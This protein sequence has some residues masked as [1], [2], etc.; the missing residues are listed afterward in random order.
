MEQTV[1]PSREE[2]ISER[3]VE[4]SIDFSVSG[5]DIPTR[6]GLKVF[7]QDRVRQRHLLLF[8]QLVQMMTRM[9]LMKGFFA[10]FPKIKV[11]SWLRT[12][13]E[14]ARQCQPI[15]AGCSAGG[16]AIAGLHRVSAAQGKL[17]WQDPLLEQTHKQDSLAG[18]SWCRGRVDRR[19]E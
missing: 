7:A 13:V 15:H 1:F 4:Q 2:R 10:L 8:L 3:I 19:K 11:R 9:S 5:G 18:T 16:R 17:R 14:G 12:R 6:G